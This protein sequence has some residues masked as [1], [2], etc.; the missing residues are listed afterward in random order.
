MAQ[1]LVSIAFED[2]V[3]GKDVTDQVFQAYGP[4]GLG[5]LTI[6]GIPSYTE[7]RAKL[8]PLA[9][10][11]AHLPED[12]KKLL[13]HEPSMWNAGWSHGKEKLGDIPDLSKGSFYAN[14]LYDDAATEADRAK[15]PFFYPKN[16]WPTEDIPE[17]EKAFKD[18]GKV[19]YDA[20]VL[21]SK[22]IDKLVSKRIPAYKDTTLSS[23]MEKTKKLKGR[24]LYYYP[25][26][27]VGDEDGWIGWHNDSGFLTA[28][29]GDLFFDDT[30]GEVIDNPDPKGGL[31]IVDRNSGSVKIEIPN[32]HLAVQCGECLQI[33]TGG[34]L[35]ATPHRVKAS[36]C[37]DRK[38]GR[39]SFPV[40]IDTTA[41][42]TLSAPEGISKEQVFD[43]TVKSRVPPLEARWSGNGQPFIEFLGDTFKQYYEWTKSLQN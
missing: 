22:Q 24:L 10:K 13:E 41:T 6:S 38:V 17:L 43:K 18:L 2:L 7:L 34:L 19:M 15:Y 40:F 33:I 14:P 27:K 42:F 4:G 8:L 20:V 16:I 31:W 1:R 11:L 30:T 32:D 9:H 25:T 26:S 35:V 36:A 21:L 23:E 28:L 5:A 3:S 29:S 12:R 39:A 37:A